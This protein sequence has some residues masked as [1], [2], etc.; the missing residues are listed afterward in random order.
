MQHIYLKLNFHR[1]QIETE[2]Q[3]YLHSTVS[4][5]KVDEGV[6]FQFFHSFQFAKLTEGL[7][8]QLLC[9]GTCQVPHKQ[10]LDLRKGEKK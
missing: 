5:L 4:F 10:H 9:N 6:V 8:Q 2:L 3:D 1:L 7:F